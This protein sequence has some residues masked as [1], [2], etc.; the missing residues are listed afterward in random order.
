METL[1]PGGVNKVVA[2]LGKGLSEKGHTVTVLQGNPLELAS[3]E[4][5]QGFKIVRIKSPLEKHLH[6]L[7]GN[8]YF[9]LKKHLKELDPHVVHLHGHV[10]V[11]PEVF[12]AVRKLD[13]SIP[14]VVNFHVDAFSGTLGR[15]LFW[16]LYTKI[17]KNV[18]KKATHV[19]ADSNFEAD[20]VRTTFSVHDDELSTI[21]LGVDPLF[22]QTLPKLRKKRHNEEIR[23]LFVGYLMKRKNVQSILYALHVLVHKLENTGVRLTIIGSGPEKAALMHLA[24]ELQVDDRI[25]WKE[26]LNE[27]E[28]LNELQAADVFLLLSKSEA[29]GIAVAEALSAGTPCIVANTTALREF[30]TEP[31]CFGVES[32]SNPEAVAELILYI[33]ENDIPVG[34][35][36]DKIRTWERV[37]QDYEAVYKKVRQDTTLS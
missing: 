30:T 32:P 34:P 6:S 13:H 29:Y 11:T 2:E 37:V 8:L 33:Y 27:A 9:Y 20:Y 31:G 28:L 26:S 10:L 3:E 17:D 22:Q 35:F 21:H 19:I 7:N 24:K 16:N 12:S 1:S 5:Y 25:T 36:S 15:R 23:M 14:T 4:I 18:A